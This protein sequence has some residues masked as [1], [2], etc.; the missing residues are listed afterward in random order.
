[1]FP[2]G[3]PARLLSATPS[4]SLGVAQACPPGSR[5]ALCQKTLV[6]AQQRQSQGPAQTVPGEGLA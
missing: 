1:M 5:H 2:M 4:A 3:G 6:H